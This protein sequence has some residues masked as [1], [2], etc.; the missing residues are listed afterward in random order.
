MSSVPTL[1]SD[2]AGTLVSGTVFGV[3]VGGVSVESAVAVLSTLPASISP[4][5]TV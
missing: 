2:S 1:V 4:W 5:V 3:S